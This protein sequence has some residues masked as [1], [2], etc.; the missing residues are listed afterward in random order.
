[1]NWRNKNGPE[2]YSVNRTLALSG[3]VT[4]KHFA[5]RQHVVAN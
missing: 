1:M 4:V 5:R 3:A 2:A